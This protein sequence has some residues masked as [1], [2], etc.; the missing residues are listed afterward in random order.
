MMKLIPNQISEVPRIPV[1]IDDTKD[2]P[3]IPASPLPKKSFAMYIVGSPGSGKTNLMLSLML[4]H[5]TKKRKNIPIYYWKYFDHIE[6]ISGSLQ[7]LPDKF[8]NKLPDEQLHNRYT[9][10]LLEGLI[11]KMKKGDNTNNLII[12]DDVIKDLKRSKIVAKVF[13][14][15]RHCT[16]S[17]EKDGVGGL[18]IMTTSQKYNLLPLEVR[19]NQSHYILFKSSNRQE[20][21]A[22][23]NELMTDL[24]PEQQEKIFEM[25][26]SKPY[27]FLMI[28][29]NRPRDEKYYCR[30]DKIIFED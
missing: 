25:C 5:P 14:N 3:Y 9:D 17:K 10:E 26:W 28:D 6:V 30:F 1:S 2:L 8:L 16:H 29:I 22:I 21:D 23:R 7:T 18:S 4:S 24:T 15:R 19:L 27:S 12:L 11:D 20:I 13:L